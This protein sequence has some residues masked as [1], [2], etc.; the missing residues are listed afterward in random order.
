MCGNNQIAFGTEIV[1]EINIGQVVG[2][3]G[4]SGGGGGGGSGGGGLFVPSDAAATTPPRDRR[5]FRPLTAQQTK[6]KS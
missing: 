5:S 1:F 6:R 2:S 4:V 3:G